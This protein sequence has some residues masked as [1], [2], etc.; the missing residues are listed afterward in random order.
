[1]EV[2]ITSNE[3]MRYSLLSCFQGVLLGA[4]L[5]EEFGVCCQ[6]WRSQKTPPLLND[7]ATDVQTNQA[8]QSDWSGWQP[9]D[10][11][12]ILTQTRQAP[13]AWGKVAVR[14]AE[15]L[16]Q[17][18]N[19]RE[20]ELDPPTELAGSPGREQETTTGGDQPVSGAELAIAALPIVLFLHDN[21]LRLQQVLSQIARQWRIDPTE[22]EAVW[23]VSQALISILKEPMTPF[24]LL[25]KLVDQIRQHGKPQD[26]QSDL[27][28]ALEQVQTLLQSSASL[29]TATL[30][31]Q[32][33]KMTSARP[34]SARPASASVYS[35]TTGALCL[36]LYC[37][38]ST[39][40]DFRLA[41]L[42]A[43]R[44]G[45]S[46]QIVCGLTGA[47]AGAYSSIA[48]LPLVWRLVKTEASTMLNWG[49]TGDQ[50]KQLATQLF[51]V[52]SGVYE[53]DASSGA[54]IPAIAAPGVIRLR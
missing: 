19:W 51:W 15:A 49:V 45:V 40:D 24:N 4:A 29:R 20:L 52:W 48:G 32:T 16:V 21:P 22:I 36:A 53:L 27:V 8:D 12:Q 25:P 26:F 11:N 42:R 47:L 38:L 31:F 6:A 9:V 39:P 23:I 41:L 7:W 44:T 5:G 43:G 28:S 37:F 33:A 3:P 10:E 17:Y 30:Q 1:M 13:F 18:G 54:G 2:T 50:I 14:W 46:P 34:V 35:T